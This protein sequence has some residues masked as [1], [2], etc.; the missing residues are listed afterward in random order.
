[1]ERAP[2][3]RQFAELAATGLT[4]LAAG[5]SG[6]GLFALSAT[7]RWQFQSLLLYVG[8]PA[9]GLL[10]V[11]T[12]IA[13]A[14]R[15]QR[16]VRGIGL[17]AVAG[18]VATVGLE[19]VRITGFRMFGS[20]PGDLPTLM[21]VKATGRIMLGPNTTATI[22][23]YAD[24]FWNGAMFGVIFALLIGGFPARRGAWAGALIGAVYGLALGYGFVTGPVP[25]S[26]GVGGVFS[27]VGV[28]E[29][30][31]TVYLAHLVFGALLGV[32]VHRFGSQLSP[33]WSPL[34]ALARVVA[35]RQANSATEH[36][37]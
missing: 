22:I 12:V 13:A 9:A 37:K 26:L 14:M 19:A 3:L 1:M 24:H 30:R 28:G 34:L 21:G 11:V 5:A 10:V 15:W 23:G 6:A 33:L 29:F 36:Q 32:L 25:R 31:T 4:L 17:G 8:A 35:G 7:E 27:T 16:V 18:V 20:M 2:T